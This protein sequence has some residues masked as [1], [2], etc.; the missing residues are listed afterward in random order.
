ME[1]T[2]LSLEFY[3]RLYAI[4]RKLIPYDDIKLIRGSVYLS[5]IGKILLI[6]DKHWY[7]RVIIL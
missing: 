4:I 1:V 3:I 7:V 2:K 5:N 6:C